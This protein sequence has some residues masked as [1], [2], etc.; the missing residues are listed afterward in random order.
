MNPNPATDTTAD[1]AAANADAIRA[2]AADLRDQ[3]NRLEA[4]ADALRKDN[5]ANAGAPTDAL[6]QA[7]TS[8]RWATARK[9]GYWTL[10]VGVVALAGS[11]VYGRLRDAGV[12]LEAGD[13]VDVV[14][15]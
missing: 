10:G 11:Y 13:L 14:V 9:I 3:A 1:T 8:R 6:K 7:R 12:E 2:Q 5:D 4:Q 15:A